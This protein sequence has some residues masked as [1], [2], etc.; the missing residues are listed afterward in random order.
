MTAHHDNHRP[1]A[2][3]APMGCNDLKAALSAYLDDELTRD[4]RLRADAHL[5]GCGRCRTLV[6]RAE[7]LDLSLREVFESDLAAA[8]RA[9]DPATVDVG[10]MQA[11][12]LAAIARADD[13]ATEPSSSAVAGRIGTDDRRR[14]LPRIAIAA[15]IAAAVFSATM[16]WKAAGR[17]GTVTPGGPG[18]F[19][20]ADGGARTVDPVAAPSGRATEL[21]SLDAD[22][23]QLLYS[24]G[25]ILTNLRKDGFEHSANR[26]ELQEVARYDELV[27]R[28]DALLTKLP[29]A[30]RPTVALARETIEFLIDASD[31]PARWEEIR[32]D[33]ERTEL[34]R[35]VDSLSEA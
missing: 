17:A 34:D 16:L 6:E 8:E 1:S 28:L 12:V 5:V 15:S 25:V 31:D 30:D 23:R 26:T 4:E 3:A 13:A 35:K 9:I 7:E 14:W 18:N 19:S 29:P 32:R 21:A 33:M 24:T 11:G 27:Q 10:A 20:L 2:A 22:E